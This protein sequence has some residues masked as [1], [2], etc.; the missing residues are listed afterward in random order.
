LPKGIGYLAKPFTPNEVVARSR[1]LL[2]T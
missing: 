2:D 1:Q